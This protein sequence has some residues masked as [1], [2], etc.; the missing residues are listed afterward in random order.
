M[1]PPDSLF[2]DCSGS[3]GSVEIPYELKDDFFLLPAKNS[4]EILMW[5]A[6]TL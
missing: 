3:L 2:L 5:I 1:K 6:L 4:I